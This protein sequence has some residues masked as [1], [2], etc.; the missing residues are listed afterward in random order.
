MD[1]LP[2]LGRWLL[3][4]LVDGQWAELVLDIGEGAEDK[5]AATA[6]APQHAIERHVVVAV[7]AEHRRAAVAGL[8]GRFDEILAEHR[9]IAQGHVGINTG[10]ADV[11]VGPAGGA[12][13]FVED[14]ADVRELL[15][16]ADDETRQEGIDVDRAPAL[17]VEVGLGDGR[18]FP[19]IEGIVE[20]EGAVA[21]AAGAPSSAGEV[22]RVSDLLADV[23]TGEIGL[24]VGGALDTPRMFVQWELVTKPNP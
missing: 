6:A 5:A 15:A 2:L 23:I 8:R 13:H 17:A 7:P 12:P 16:T 19:E 3:H 21:I 4:V 24:V 10:G 18:E 20:G 14:L 11:A 1:R 9:H 22:E